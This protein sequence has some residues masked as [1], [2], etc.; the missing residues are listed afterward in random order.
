[1]VI[2]RALCFALCAVNIA[3]A[4]L[5][6]AEP[7]PILISPGP[8]QDAHDR[9]P[10]IGLRYSQSPQVLMRRR[11]QPRAPP[12][13][14]DPQPKSITSSQNSGPKVTPASS[15]DG[16]TKLPNVKAGSSASL[17]GNYLSSLR[18]TVKNVMYQQLSVNSDRRRKWLAKSQQELNEAGRELPHFGH[19]PAAENRLG[20]KTLDDETYKKR[21]EEN[22]ERGQRY[23]SLKQGIHDAHVG[24]DKLG[25]LMKEMN[26]PSLRTRVSE[27]R[28]VRPP[29]SRTKSLPPLGALRSPGQAEREQ[30]MA[31]S[32][33][34][35]KEKQLMDDMNVRM[36]NRKLQEVRTRSAGEKE[37]DDA[38]ERVHGS[39]FDMYIRQVS[40]SF[41]PAT[42]PTLMRNSNP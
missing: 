42:S 31:Q 6:H 36:N 27:R 4:M 38:Q 18:D 2:T 13:E 41:C 17:H 34:D 19:A 24:E 33:W 9:H 12:A 22:E 14:D 1:M 16:G 8:S 26:L 15:S 23:T 28:L 20:G 11:L 30:R 40:A 25:P 37:H 21:L 10:T 5:G 32:L 39:A 7:L 29:I 35:H 3:S